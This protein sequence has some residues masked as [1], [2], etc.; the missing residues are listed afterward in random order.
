MMKRMSIHTYR[1]WTVQ[2][3]LY[4]SSTRIAQRTVH[5]PDLLELYSI[6]IF[7]PGQKIRSPSP[8]Y[9][10]FPPPQMDRNKGPASGVH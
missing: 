7:T 1:S 6:D 4:V 2:T 9:R 3:I 8:Q 10:D 5:N